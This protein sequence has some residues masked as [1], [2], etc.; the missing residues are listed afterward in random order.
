MLDLNL[1]EN[2][3]KELEDTDTNF[4]TCEK[5]ASLYII[6]AYHQP[7]DVQYS[8][9]DEPNIRK[10]LDDILPHYNIYCNRKAEYQLGNIGKEP[11]IH[12]F[13]AVCKELIEFITVFYNNTD[14][15]EERD[16]LKEYL[17]KLNIH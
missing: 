6:R 4:S 2:T 11:V 7:S 17:E 5:L 9:E 1:I 3:I 12:S 15:I 13:K 14:M 16:I 8:T 10:E